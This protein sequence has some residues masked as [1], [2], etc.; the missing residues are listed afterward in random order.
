MQ[1][2]QTISFGHYAELC[3]ISFTA[4]RNRWKEWGGTGT[5]AQSDIC[6]ALFLSQF[7]ISKGRMK[8][9]TAAQ[10]PPVSN[11]RPRSSTNTRKKAI[12]APTAKFEAN[13]NPLLFTTVDVFQPAPTHELQPTP[14]PIPAQVSEPQPAAETLPATE[15]RFDRANLLR[16]INVTE[17]LLGF[18]GAFA[19][20]GWKGLVPMVAAQSYY[21]YCV[22]ELQQDDDGERRGVSLFVCALLAGWFMYVH[23]QTFHMLSPDYWN[24]WLWAVITSVTGWLALQKTLPK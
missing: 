12:V 19:Q 1:E 13:A 6:P 10:V 16:V 4:V 17:T 21:W 11:V 23:S 20:Y 3:G 14:Q 7:P 18:V 2:V 15:K 9:A 5:L 8:R 22:L 24:G